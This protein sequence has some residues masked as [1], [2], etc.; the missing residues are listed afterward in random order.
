MLAVEFDTKDRREAVVAACLER[1]L[2]VLGCG[3]KTLRLLPPLDVTEREIDLALDVFL[4]AIDDRSVRQAGA[5][6][7]DTD[8]VA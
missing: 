1:G 2:L 7:V 6:K 8:N 3:Y 4:D 5:S